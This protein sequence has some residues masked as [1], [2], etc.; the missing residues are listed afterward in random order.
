MDKG[1]GEDG[2]KKRDDQAP[3]PAGIDPEYAD[4][5]QSLLSA[6]ARSSSTAVLDG[7]EE[8]AAGFQRN[9]GTLQARLSE[10]L[11]ERLLY[12]LRDTYRQG[13]EMVQTHVMDPVNQAYAQITAEYA[14]GLVQTHMVEP[15]NQAYQDMS[16]RATELVQTNV[17]DPVNQAYNEA[18]LYF[19]SAVVDPLKDAYARAADMYEENVVKPTVRATGDFTNF[20]STYGLWHDDDKGAGGAEKTVKGSETPK[21]APDY[22]LKPALKRRDSLTIAHKGDQGGASKGT[23]K[24]A[25]GKG[26]PEAGAKDHKVKFG[27]EQV[28]TLPPEKKRNKHDFNEFVEDQLGKMTSRP[29]SQKESKELLETMMKE[30]QAAKAKDEKRRLEPKSEETAEEAPTKAAGNAATGKSV[31]GWVASPEEKQEYKK[32][33]DMLHS[34]GAGKAGDDG[35]KAKGTAQKDAAG[36]KAEAKSEDKSKAKEQDQKKPE[37]GKPAGDKKGE[38]TETKPPPGEKSEGPPG[39]KA[40]AKPS[41]KAASVAAAT[42]PGPAR[43]PSREGAEV[44]KSSS[45][46]KGFRRFFRRKPADEESSE[47]A[48]I[49]YREMDE[50]FIECVEDFG[51]GDEVG[52]QDKRPAGAAGGASAAA[53]EEPPRQ[54]KLNACALVTSGFVIFIVLLAIL[55]SGDL[56][57]D[58]DNSVPTF[59][60]DTSN[61]INVLDSVRGARN[62]PLLLRGRRGWRGFCPRR[63]RES[64]QIGRRRIAGLASPQVVIQRSRLRATSL[65][66]RERFPLMG[67]EWISLNQFVERCDWR[68]LFSLNAH[69]LEDVEPSS[70]VY[71]RWDLRDAALLMRFSERHNLT[72]RLMWQLGEAAADNWPGPGPS[73]YALACE[74]EALRDLVAFYPAPLV[75]PGVSTL[76]KPGLRYLERF[77]KGRGRFVDVVSLRHV[78]H[79]ASNVTVKDLLDF[80]VMERFDSDL[81]S[82]RALVETA[83]PRVTRIWLTSLATTA[84]FVEGVSGTFAAMLAWTE[85]F[86]MAAKRGVAAVLHDSLLGTSAESLIVATNE[87]GDGAKPTADYW[88]ML[89]LARH[90]GQKVLTIE[91]PRLNDPATRMYVHC[92]RNH[93]GG[94]A[95]YG[96]RLADTAAK[97]KKSGSRQLWE[98]QL[99]WVLTPSSDIG[100]SGV[101]L[102]GESLSWSGGDGTNPPDPGPEELAY[103]II[104]LPAWSMGLFVFPDVKAKACYDR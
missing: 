46:G 60:I 22:P 54:Y 44:K 3:R 14:A 104:S 66:S 21:S 37:G 91:G 8:G 38:K 77:V 1:G 53:A 34:K 97:L 6:S 67:S 31:A 25:D 83:A 80:A 5:T 58:L 33:Q 70:P 41:E 68:L 89:L 23:E 45:W 49:P 55:L 16:A 28:R 24:Q 56:F 90:V 65:N 69:R 81:Q 39:E 59:N 27:Y 29:T 40:G 100:S 15:M 94:L 96:V 61:V 30:A 99:R 74:Y 95:F 63:E 87:G 64:Q 13:T 103:T 92:A 78:L 73:P 101:Y 10:A 93:P 57:D 12:P 2:G 17:V 42:G 35:A 9:R 50:E 82:V 19:Q 86:G 20:L 11:N 43:R 84:G 4:F 79:E 88:A 51:A 52:G 47:E 76:R 72:S 75:G 62:R 71:G 36:A 98:R 32:F 26:G 85:A 18:P 102:N 7:G 48:R